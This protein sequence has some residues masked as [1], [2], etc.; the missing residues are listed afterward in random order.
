[1]I[2]TE[3]QSAPLAL[4][5]LEPD[6]SRPVKVDLSLPTQLD[7][8]ISGIESRRAFAASMRYSLSFSVF[9][10]N[11]PESTK[12]R[13]WLNTLRDE[14]VAVPLWT[15]VLTL[16]AGVSAGAEALTF[17]SLPARYGAEWLLLNLTSGLWE[18]V[19]VES[20]IGQTA[21]LAAGT[22]GAWTAGTLLMPLLFGRLAARPSLESITDRHAEGTISFDE[23]SPWAQRISPAPGTIPTVG[24]GITEFAD[25]KLFNVYPDAVRM[26]DST[27]VDIDWETIG[28][29]REDQM[30][31]NPAAVRRSV[32]FKIASGGREEIAAVERLWTDRL[33]PV[34][35]F[36]LPTHRSDLV[37]TADVA[38]GAEELPVQS[39]A[40]QDADYAGHPGHPF[41]ALADDSIIEAVKVPAIG[42][43]LDLAA[44]TE[45]AFSKDRT[46]VSHL[47]LARF[48]E[49]KISWSYTTDQHAESS[50][51]FL[52]APEEYETGPVDLPVPAWCYKFTVQL[53]SVQTFRYTS[54]ERAITISGD[55]TYEPAPFSHRGAQITTKFDSDE[56][57]LR[58]WKFDENPLN[59]FFPFALEKPL[60]LQIRE[61]DADDPDG[62]PIRFSGEVTECKIEGMEMTA[63]A[64]SLGAVLERK[65]P[66]F[67][68]QSTCNYTVYSPQC[69]LLKAV[70]L[71][72]GAIVS[73]D[74]Q[75]VVVDGMPEDNPP[76]DWFSWGWFEVGTGAARQVRAI[77]KSVPDGETQ[78]LTLNR[79][80]TSY[81]V[82][83][84]VDIFPGCD[85]L[86]ET[87]REKFNNYPQFGGHAFVPDQNPALKAL[88]IENSGGGKK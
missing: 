80:L 21:N 84:A 16:S 31:E 54:F 76:E 3:Y 43:T 82:G 77:L 35:L 87:C 42:L 13:L 64:I 34:R 48:S 71:V 55:G 70:F 58:S 19:E 65:F 47:L 23:N 79:P 29:L 12:L 15:D 26:I 36:M 30:L 49:N 68:I 27:E 53:P 74:G 50:L 7:R 45:N 39:S 78:I 32:Q 66:G 85:G 40:Y 5:L 24:A 1:M 38:E 81:E 41:L 18:I 11:G 4:F 37:L 69:G 86:R 56:L 17:T 25:L 9:T 75:T 22:S 61:A 62:A 33:G 28:F 44:P 46:N 57:E 63:K 83:W 14:K 67:F 52:E 20:I 6:W 72:E 60:K 73:V 59:L 2:F 10:A 8:A 88:P 51:K